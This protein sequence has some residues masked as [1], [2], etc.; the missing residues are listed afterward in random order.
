MLRSLPRLPRIFGS[1]AGALML[2]GCMSST[3]PRTDVSV[4]YYD[5]RGTSFQEL[6]REIALHGPLVEGVGKAIAATRVRMIPDIRY[7]TEA[8]R[9]QVASARIRVK[10]DVTLPRLTDRRRVNED[11]SKAFS[12]I[13]EYARLHEAVHVQ[14]ADDHARKAEQSI[15]ALPAQPDCDRLSSSVM[16]AFKAVL[17]KHDKAQLA[18]DERERRRFASGSQVL[19]KTS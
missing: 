14:I 5:V 16:R 10:A 2:A 9:C 3:G 7:R 12:N 8:S 1:L 4:G 18:F 13:E 15:L 17:E 11:M 6:D 19:K